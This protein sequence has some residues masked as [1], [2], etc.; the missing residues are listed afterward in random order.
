M[1]QK[2]SPQQIQL[3]KLLQILLL[4][5]WKRIKEELEANPALEEG[6]DDYNDVFDLDSDYDSEEKQETEDTADYE[7]DDYL[8]QYLE[9]DGDS[10]LKPER[11]W[12]RWR[13]WQN[14]TRCRR[15]YFHD[16]LNRQ[17]D[18]GSWLLKLMRWLP[19]KLFGSIDEDGYLRSWAQCHHRRY[20]V[21][22]GAWKWAKEDNPRIQFG[23]KIW[24]KLGWSS[25]GGSH[26]ATTQDK[27]DKS[28]DHSRP[29]TLPWKSW[30]TILKSLTKALSKLKRTYNISD[31]EL[32]AIWNPQ[33]QSKT[34]QH[35]GESS[36]HQPLYC[37]RL[38][39]S[40]PW[41]WTGT[42]PQHQKFSW[43]PHQWTICWNVAWIQRQPERQKKST[44]KDKAI[45][46]IKQKLILPSGSSMPSNSARIPFTAP[47]MPSCRFRY[48]YF[49]TGD[50]RRVKPMILKDICRDHMARYIYCFKMPIQSLF[51]P[52]LVPNAW[53]TFFL[54]LCQPPTAMRCLL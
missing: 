7:L 12:L 23:S 6:D 1:L 26:S 4:P 50:E 21:P 24:S 39:H 47:C 42:Q 11:R 43:P 27:M 28:G 32:Q 16:M 22:V 51:K 8:N 35:G 45:L 46:F 41:W 37:T 44:R 30:L 3:M 48:D 29:R 49:L 19:D 25:L 38:Y 15:K 2:L 52:N 31:S 20:Y 33:T 5:F 10:Y 9:D 18:D 40:Q 36:K 53:K 17:L 34:R 13:K 14:H 54:S